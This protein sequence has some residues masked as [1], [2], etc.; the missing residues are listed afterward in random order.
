MALIEKLKNTPKPFWG[1]QRAYE[2]EPCSTLSTLGVAPALH[3]F[4]LNNVVKNPDKLPQAIDMVKKLNEKGIIIEFDWHTNHP[5][6]NKSKTES[7][8][9]AVIPGVFESPKFQSDLDLVSKFFLEIQKLGVEYI[10]RPFHEMNLDIF[11]WGV[12]NNPE[13]YKSLFR[14]TIN[15]LKAKGCAPIVVFSPNYRGKVT[16][17]HYNIFYPGDDCVDI[18]GLD[19]YRFEMLKFADNLRFLPEFAKSKNK[20]LAFPE[21][22]ISIRGNGWNGKLSTEQKLT[23][24]SELGQFLSLFPFCY[25]RNW[26]DDGY[27]PQAHPESTAFSAFIKNQCIH[28]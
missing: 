21:N 7:S 8:P 5:I 24:I 28:A 12:H 4:P 20:L 16:E 3:G 26:T 1:V 15:Y 14:Q 23:H 17:E 22:G 13:D 25:Y 2:K 9:L 10:F 27:L 18:I 6:T 11:W 19:W